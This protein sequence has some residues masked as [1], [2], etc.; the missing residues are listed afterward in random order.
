MKVSLYD[1]LS[2]EIIMDKIYPQLAAGEYVWEH[3]LTLNHA[4]GTGYYR[5][6]YLEGIHIGYGDIRLKGATQLHFESDFETVEMHFA[7]KGG[8]TAFATTFE[9]AHTF[10]AHQHNIVYGHQMCGKMDWNDKDF[11]IFEVNM[12][13]EFFCKYLPENEAVFHD[14]KNRISKKQS[15]LLQT[16]NKPISHQ[17]LLVINDI[18]TCNRKGMYQRIFLEAK[19]LELL[20]L[21]LEQL[22]EHEQPLKLKQ[23]DI[24]KMY[25][26]RDFL[27]QNLDTPCSLLDLAHQ[28]STNEYALKKGFKALFGD[29]VFGFWNEIKMKEA[30]EL[31]LK[32]EMNVNE[33]ADA[34]GYRNARHFSTA[35]KKKFGISPGGLKKAN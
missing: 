2:S 31:L 5:E 18:M 17:M 8:T 6:L 20:L 12:N 30:R 10:G 25:A 35:F 9:R 15:G 19:V 14:F 28:F 27:Q 34:V 1:A 29:T 26:V 23:A 24:D 16:Q 13:P 7:L 11:C 21:Q 4:L 32:Q 3:V 33:V 22:N